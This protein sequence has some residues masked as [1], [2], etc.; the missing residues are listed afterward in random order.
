MH[1]AA[2]WLLQFKT[3]VF[4]PI[5]SC[6]DVSNLSSE[7]HP[8]SKVMQNSHWLQQALDIAQ[9]KCNCPNQIQHNKCY[10]QICIL[11]SAYLPLWC[12]LWCC[13]C[14]AVL[15]KEQISSNS[16]YHSLCSLSPCT[17]IALF[18][19]GEKS[20]SEFG[21][22]VKAFHQPSPMHRC[23]TYVLF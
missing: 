21:I 2:Y 14:S 3:R 5:C 10:N 9:S 17:Q 19:E 13:C 8:A 4:A 23:S 22:N 6:E 20:S 16:G 12:C 1:V 11:S 7:Q 18:C 15:M